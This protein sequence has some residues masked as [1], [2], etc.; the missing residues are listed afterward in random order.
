MQAASL[1]A[2]LFVA[3]G[4]AD[5]IDLT[6]AGVFA[7]IPRAAARSGECPDRHGKAKLSLRLEPV[8]HLRLKLAVAHL[9]RSA[10][11]ILIAA[12]DRYLDEATPAVHDGGCACFMESRPDETAGDAE[13]RRGPAIT[14]AAAICPR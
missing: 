7:R 14:A 1:T 3:K 6:P 4:R 10:Q 9:N 5:P 8:R 12:L 2:S 13:D 11:Q